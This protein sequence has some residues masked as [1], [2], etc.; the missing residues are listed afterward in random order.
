MKIILKTFAATVIAAVISI[1]N[2]DAQ[3]S[4]GGSSVNNAATFA[5]NNVTDME[6]T[7]SSINARALKNFQ[8]TFTGVTNTEWSEI[9]GEGY[10]ANFTDGS[11]RTIVAYNLK[12][13]WLHTI[14]YYDEKKLAPAIRHIVKSTY[15]DYTI[16]QI[17]EV[18]F[19]DQTVYMIYVQDETYLK[20]IRVFDGEM[21]VVQTYTRG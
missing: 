8:K 1:H 9:E 12:G 7:A 19:S 5:I 16:L 17:A 18:S 3:I 10:V 21:E 6:G 4:I 15:Y 11:V 14:R 2:A 20:T 13:N